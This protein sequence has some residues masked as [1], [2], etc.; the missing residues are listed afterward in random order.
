[1]FLQRSEEIFDKQIVNLDYLLMVSDCCFD[2]TVINLACGPVNLK[3]GRG[4]LH[5][6][7]SGFLKRNH[8]L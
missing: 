5:S 1:M 4:G 6:F 7:V 3:F 8:A 2:V